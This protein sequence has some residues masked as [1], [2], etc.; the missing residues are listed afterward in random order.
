MTQHQLPSLDFRSRPGFRDSVD[1]EIV[2]KDGVISSG[3]MDGA[4]LF[5][6]KSKD[7]SLKSQIRIPHLSRMGS[8]VF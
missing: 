2:S 4:D 6:S 3:E 7:V 1:E 5:H 8:Q